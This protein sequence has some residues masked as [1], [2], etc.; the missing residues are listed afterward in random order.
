MAKGEIK[1]P[2][3][4][5]QTTTMMEEQRCSFTNSYP[6]HLTEMTGWL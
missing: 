5:I 1:L 2:Q 3:R 4:L 6:N